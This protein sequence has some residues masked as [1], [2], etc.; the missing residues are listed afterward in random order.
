MELPRIITQLE[1]VDVDD[2]FF[3]KKLEPFD[4]RHAHSV[5]MGCSLRSLLI[6]ISVHVRSEF[7]HIPIALN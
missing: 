5:N 2:N 3:L 4:G 6:I 7:I 1:L